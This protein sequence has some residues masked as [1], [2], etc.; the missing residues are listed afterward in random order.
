[1]VRCC[2]IGAVAVFARIAFVVGER[3]ISIAADSAEC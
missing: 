1:M 2:V 3:S